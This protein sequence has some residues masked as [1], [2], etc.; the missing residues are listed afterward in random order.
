MRRVSS[1][2]SRRVAGVSSFRLTTLYWSQ[3]CEE[4]VL[5]QRRLRLEEPMIPVRMLRHLYRAEMERLASMVREARRELASV[6][7]MAGLL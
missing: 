5:Y 7:K 6:K 4:A 1:V 3:V 2:E